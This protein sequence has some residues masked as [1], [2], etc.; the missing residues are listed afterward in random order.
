MNSDQGVRNFLCEG[1][2]RVSI[3]FYIVISVTSVILLL[4]DKTE[5]EKK[6]GTF[7]AQLHGNS[8]DGRPMSELK[9]IYIYIYIYIYIPF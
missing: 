4:K 5:K 8:T 3:I 9:F 2:G 7:C 6:E 1:V